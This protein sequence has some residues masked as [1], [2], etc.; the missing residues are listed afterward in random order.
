[1]RTIKTYRKVGAFYI[2][3]E[4]D[5]STSLTKSASSR[6]FNSFYSFRTH[7]YSCAA[8]LFLGRALRRNSRVVFSL[9]NLRARFVSLHRLGVAHQTSLRSRATMMISS[10]SPQLGRQV[11]YSLIRSRFCRTTVEI[12][13]PRIDTTAFLPR[14]SATAGTLGNQSGHA[15]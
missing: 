4:A 3:W 7:S 11:A 1:M 10:N 13:H 6:V 12:R 15:S 14:F 9:S 2:A 8:P 5:F